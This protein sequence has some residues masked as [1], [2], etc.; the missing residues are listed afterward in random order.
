MT[1]DDLAKMLNGREIGNE[2]D[3]EIIDAMNG[4][5]LV[6]VFGLSD[7]NMAFNGAIHDEVGCY[8]GGKAY[9]EKTG[10]LQNECDEDDCPYFKELKLKADTIEA[11]WCAESNVA[12]TYKTD[13]PHST[14]DIMEGEDIFC[15]GIV[16]DL[17]TI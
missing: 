16:F 7:D 17:S 10:L 1:K 3:R 12:W 4:T 2:I 9:I 11:L 6:I 5:N 14:F 15:R 8:N 13:I